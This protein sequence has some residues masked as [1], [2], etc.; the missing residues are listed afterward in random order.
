MLLKKG[1]GSHGGTGGTTTTGLPY[2]DVLRPN[3]PGSGGR[4]G[5]GGASITINVNNNLIFGGTINMN[6]ASCTA[7][8]CGGGAGG[9]IYLYVGGSI[10]GSGTVTT[11]GGNAHAGSGRGGSGGRIGV[12]STT[13]ST[14]FVYS[15]YGGD[16][17]IC[18]GPGTTY[19]RTNNQPNGYVYLLLFDM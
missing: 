3:L 19:L 18:G 4:S 7:T 9:S 13:R 17:A 10:T 2:G 14:T 16:A 5:A 8:N 15:N 6:G 1:G 11:I 12:Y